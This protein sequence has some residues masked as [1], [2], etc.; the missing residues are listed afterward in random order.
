MQARELIQKFITKVSTFP[1]TT[2]T[3]ED[4]QYLFNVVLDLVGEGDETPV[5]AQETTTLID[6]K[7]ALVQLAV[8]HQRIQDLAAERDIL[9]LS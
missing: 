8:D 5:V 9:A 2:Y 3:A 1:E 7:E 4:E 6:L